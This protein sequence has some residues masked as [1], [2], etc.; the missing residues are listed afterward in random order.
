MYTKQQTFDMVV[1]GLRKQGCRSM[2]PSNQVC[3]YRSKDGHKC[4]AGMLIPDEDYK[5]DFEMCVIEPVP[6]CRTS[7]AQRELCELIGK[8]H[9]LK[10]V[11]DLQ[12]IH[13]VYDFREW[14]E[15]WK[16]TALEHELMYTPPC[17]T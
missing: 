16:N 7:E 8:N 11:R 1:E 17:T 12:V 14:E 5:V 13:D 15:K 6:T 9:D 2:D 10:L 3:V 4:A